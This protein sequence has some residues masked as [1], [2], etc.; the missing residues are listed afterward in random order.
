M[1]GPSMDVSHVG[2]EIPCRPS[3]ASRYG[4]LRL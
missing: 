4:A 2:G 3:R 1:L